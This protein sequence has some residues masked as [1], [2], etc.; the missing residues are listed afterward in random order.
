MGNPNEIK[1]ILTVERDPCTNSKTIL[2]KN[3]LS[4]SNECLEEIKPMITQDHERLKEMS[5]AVD[6]HILKEV[7]DSAINYYQKYDANNLNITLSGSNTESLIN[8][9]QSFLIKATEN[10]GQVQDQEFLYRAVKSV[11]HL[12][13]NVFR[14]MNNDLEQNET[15]KRLNSTFNM[16]V[17][18]FHQFLVQD[19][20]LK[21][22]LEDVMSQV[23][24]TKPNIYNILINFRSKI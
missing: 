5:G 9:F 19:N 3:P 22:M 10:I 1:I 20:E 12:Q 13:V 15:Y 6:G 16:E 17:E 8:D 24:E 21:S 4:I 23:K 11:N 18:F 14:C 7:Y 2:I